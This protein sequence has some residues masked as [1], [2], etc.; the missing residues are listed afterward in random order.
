MD[1]YKIIGKIIRCL[2]PE[3]AHDLAIKS[4][5]F[6]LVPKITAIDNS[7]LKQSF[8]GLN[9][10]NPVG[11]AAGFDKNAEAVNGLLG[12]GFG[13]LELGTVTPL[14]QQGNPQPRLFRLKEDD[15]IINRFGFNSKGVSIFADNLR[16]RKQGGIIGAN[17]GKNKDS[18][19]AIHDYSVTLEET[20]N[21]VDYVT[22]NIS[23]PNTVG[24]RDLQQK[25]SLL[26]LVKAIEIKKSALAEI[27][28]KKKPLFYKIAPDLEE[29]DLN[30]I[31]EIALEN[32]IDGLIVS[33]TTVSRPS[34]L[35][36][37]SKDEKGG[38]SGKPLFEL[39]NKT[40]STVNKLANGKIF[41]IGVGGIS[42]G[43]D[44]YE[45]IKCGASLVQVYSGLV[46]HGFELVKE[47]NLE[48]INLLEKDGLKNVSEAVGVN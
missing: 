23:S 2:P 33:N 1:Y 32:N 46:Y 7:L 16:K 48:L 17:I 3:T 28:N 19:D 12:Q 29:A 36:N 43:K 21:L 42:S 40:L 9:F 8:F 13:F 45:K 24:L 34:Y 14:Q 15:A 38:L 20:Y 35:K 18:L 11:L 25:K 44:A 22:V 47:I 5:K 6:G 30:D 10:N 4:L 39:S 27:H 31:V 26:E 37:L 41:L